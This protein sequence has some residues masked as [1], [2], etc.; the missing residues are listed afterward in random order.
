MQRIE[1]IEKMGTGIRRMQKMLAGAG[2]P[3]IG[4]TFS[5]FVRAVFFRP[6]NEQ[7]NLMVKDREFDYYAG[8]PQASYEY[9]AGTPQAKRGDTASILAFCGIPRSRE[10]IQAYL[11]LKD[12]EHF[13]LGILQPLLKKGLLVPTIPDK[14]NSPKQKYLAVKKR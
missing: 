3:P 10:E 5:S 4:Y 12:R 2:L 13:R 9:P 11:G 14:P 8:A 1:Y 6:R 7:V